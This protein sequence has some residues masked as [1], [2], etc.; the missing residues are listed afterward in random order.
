LYTGYGGERFYSS[1]ED[2]EDEEQQKKEEDDEPD[3]NRT[4][5]SD[6]EELTPEERNMRN[7][8]LKNTT[9]NAHAQ[10]LLRDPPLLP[11]VRLGQERRPTPPVISVRKGG[12]SNHW[13]F[14][15]SLR[16]YY[17]CLPGGVKQDL[18]R[19]EQCVKSIKTSK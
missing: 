1:D 16:D 7:V 13:I 14:Y 15:F 4:A 2:D 12:P 17:Y 5:A 18:N 8:T 19:M 6:T 10:N 3:S 9:F 11:P